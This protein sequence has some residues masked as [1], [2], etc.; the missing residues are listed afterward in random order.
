MATAKSDD[1]GMNALGSFVIGGVCAVVVFGMCAGLALS[2]GGTAWVDPGGLICL[3]I[4]GGG[5]GLIVRVIYNKGKRSGRS[6]G[7]PA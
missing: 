5:L 2:M 6:G 3:F 1:L 4:A 7:P